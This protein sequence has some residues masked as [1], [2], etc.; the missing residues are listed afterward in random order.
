MSKVFLNLEIDKVSVSIIVSSSIS[1]IIYI[2]MGMYNFQHF[3]I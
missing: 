1:D 3:Q 2:R